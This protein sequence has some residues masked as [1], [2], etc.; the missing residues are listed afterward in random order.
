M[1]QDQYHLETIALHGGQVVDSD[2]HSRAV[3]I[4]QTSSYCFNDTDHAARLFRFQPSPLEQVP[5]DRAGAG[6]G[7]RTPGAPVPEPPRPPG[8]SGRRAPTR[9]SDD[10]SANHPPQGPGR[11]GSS[12]GRPPIAEH[13]L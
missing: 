4:Y 2:T 1:G 5:A 13:R 10:S 6:V 3:P 12:T 8:R 7:W 9:D 11:D